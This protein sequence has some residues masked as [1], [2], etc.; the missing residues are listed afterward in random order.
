ML[1]SFAFSGLFFLKFWKASKDNFFLLFSLACFLLAIERLLLF[2][3]LPRYEIHTPATEAQ[4]LV[5]LVRAAAFCLIMV[6]VVQR[7][8]TGGGRLR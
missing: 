3:L 6:A 8:R 7:N 4:A 1:A 5:Y 2:I